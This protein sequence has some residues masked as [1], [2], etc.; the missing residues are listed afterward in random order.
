MNPGDTRPSGPS[1]A[2]RRSLNEG[3]G[4]NPGDTLYRGQALDI[5]IPL[6]EG[7]GVNPGDTCLRDIVRLSG[8]ARSTKAGA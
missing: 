7:R 6:N 3:R 5:T 4:V 1:R 8:H 2:R